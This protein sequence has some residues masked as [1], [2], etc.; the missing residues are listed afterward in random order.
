MLTLHNTPL[1]TALHKIG[2]LKCTEGVGKPEVTLDTADL[3][4]HRDLAALA[5]M[6]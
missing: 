6:N 2:A 3:L 5:T 1:T 4:P